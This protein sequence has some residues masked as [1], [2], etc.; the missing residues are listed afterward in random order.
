MI[1]I[2]DQDLFGLFLDSVKS[3]TPENIAKRIYDDRE[4]IHDLKSKIMDMERD[5]ESLKKQRIIDSQEVAYDSDICVSV[6]ERSDGKFFA[7]GDTVVRDDSGYIAAQVS[8]NGEACDTKTE[9]L[10]ELYISMQGS[11]E[12]AVKSLKYKVE[13]AREVTN[14]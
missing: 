1:E 4:Q 3:E 2:K 8:F 9:A 14:D 12:K 11:T 10:Q 6:K 5:L 7:T 13:E